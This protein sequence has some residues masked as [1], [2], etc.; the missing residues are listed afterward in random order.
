MARRPRGARLAAS[1]GMSK[2]KP[3][4][5]LTNDLPPPMLKPHSQTAHLL[6]PFAPIPG[7]PLHRCDL[8][9]RAEQQICRAILH[10]AHA[11]VEQDDER[12]DDHQQHD[13]RREDD[14][15]QVVAHRPIEG[16][17]EEAATSIFTMQED[18]SK[19]SQP[20][21]NRRK[22]KQQE[23]GRT[24]QQRREAV[25]IRARAAPGP[26]PVSSAT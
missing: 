9:A 20:A 24:R 1:S 5:Q 21:I 26:P 7:A 2:A 3:A 12:S 18:A 11:Q 15:L 13:K 8:E 14:E 4:R 25:I 17:M 6:G 19:S 22:L 10:H 23:S 16:D